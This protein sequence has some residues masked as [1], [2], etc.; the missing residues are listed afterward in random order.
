MR[1]ILALA[2]LAVLG[3]AGAGCGATKTIVVNVETNSLATKIANRHTGTTG[4]I[5]VVAPTTTTVSNVKP[6][7]QIRCKAGSGAS[8]L[9]VSLVASRWRQAAGTS[10][11][12]SSSVSM[13]LTP[14]HDGSSGSRADQRTRNLPVVGVSHRRP[15]RLRL[16]NPRL[17]QC[18]GVT[19]EGARAVV[20]YESLAS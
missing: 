2:L 10:G 11:N 14:L 9:A 5:T 3:F 20:P 6:D 15:A 17:G 12:G 16:H 13:K 18:S 4:T 1:P 8:V 7:T 19:P